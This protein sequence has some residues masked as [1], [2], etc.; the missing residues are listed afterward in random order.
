MTRPR[1][2]LAAICLLVVSGCGRFE[3]ATT[4]PPSTLDD[5]PSES[6]G[7]AFEPTPEGAPPPTDPPPVAPL[8]APPTA[9][10]E[11]PSGTAAPVAAAGGNVAAATTDGLEVQVVAEGGP[12]YGSRPRFRIQVILTNRCD[13]TRY[14]AI[15]QGNF[16]SLFD[17]AGAAVWKSASCNST[18]GVYEISGGAAPIEPGQAVSVVVDYPQAGSGEDCHVADGSYTLHGVF[19]ICPDEEVRETSNP[20]TYRCPE[21]AVEPVASAGLAITIG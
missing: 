5:R 20:G 7:E 3:R 19:P 11:A 18:M 21:D 15:G 2:A 14:H 16:A 1:V 17:A 8:T 9:A 4:T 6:P 13:R 12:R 10:V